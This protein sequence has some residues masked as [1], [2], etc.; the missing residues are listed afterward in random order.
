M[1][2]DYGG[3]GPRRQDARYQFA[4]LISDALR[5]HTSAPV[6]GKANEFF[7]SALRYVFSLVGED[8]LDLHTLAE[9]VIQK[10]EVIRGCGVML[11]KPK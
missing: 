2:N 1:K 8:R 10:H 7:E 3:S 5:T 9:T 6:T 11:V 4:A